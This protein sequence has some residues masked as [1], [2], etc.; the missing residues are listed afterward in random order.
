MTRLQRARSGKTRLL[1]LGAMVAVAIGLG[2]P[3]ALLRREIAGYARGFRELDWSRL[4]FTNLADGTGPLYALAIWPRARKNLE[5]LV[6]MHGY[7]ESAAQYFSE[8]RYWATQGRFVLLP[9]MRGRKSDLAYP[10]DLVAASDPLG[11]HLPGWRR[12][13]DFFGR[14]LAADQLVSAGEPD[15]GGTE[16][17]DISSAVKAARDR[18]GDLLAPGTDILGYSGGGTSA[19]LAAAKSPYS[20]D[21]VVAFFPILDFAKQEEHLSRLGRGPLREIRAWIGGT[22]AEV[23]ERYAAR[24]VLGLVEN[25][26]H[27][28]P[29]VFADR[30][31]ALCPAP[32]V[33]E[34]A[35]RIPQG[36]PLRVV[37][38]G[39]G[40]EIRWRHI[41]PDEHSDM[42]RFGDRVFAEPR[43]GS[44]VPL[45]TSE[46]WVVAG[47][48]RLPDLEIDL[49]D[50]QGGVV[51]VAVER[52][53]RSMVLDFEPV[54]PPATMAAR[55]R[56]RLGGS[57]IELAGVKPDGSVVVAPPAP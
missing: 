7:T 17:L 55:I 11:F 4:E 31:D 50:R 35:T 39:P 51:R 56:A 25:L 1:G 53:E 6:I 9:D 12:A 3:Y 21:R 45:P 22:P 54:V 8:A 40:D 26:R 19:L 46:S 28:R 5:L 30:E 48:L 29:W 33:Q 16:L 38:S 27:S 2:V 36:H 20:F 44:L 41:N 47:Y 37:P 34:L 13:V 42:H 24:S 32:V 18:F 43:R 49:G 52:R 15:S 14:P 57:W 23:P 10:L